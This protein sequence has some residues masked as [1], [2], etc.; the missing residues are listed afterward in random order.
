MIGLERISASSQTGIER[1]RLS[2][3]KF[4]Q[5][6][7][8]WPQLDF[9]RAGWEMLHLIISPRKVYQSA[10]HHKQTTNSYARDDPAFIILLNLCIIVSAL[11]WGL[12]YKSSS[13]VA[14]LKLIIYMVGIDFYVTGILVATVAYVVLTGGIRRER[15][16]R[17]EWRYCFDVH[18]NG[19]VAIFL[20][21]YGIQF[22]LMP[23][24]SRNIWICKAL[25]N[26]LYLVAACYYWYVTF[27]GYNTIVSLKRPELYLLPMAAS[28]IIWFISLFTF[29]ATHIVINWYINT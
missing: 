28:V 6:F 12:A 22:F 11:A 20:F 26:T 17:I 14:I 21:L 29:S 1:S 7:V 4:V 5:R 19:F 24:L 27:L 2:A 3:G 8:K 16:Q 13:P 25:G 15:T 18:C 10:Y 9:E 23:I